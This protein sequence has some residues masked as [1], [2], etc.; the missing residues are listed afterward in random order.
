MTNIIK[1]KNE[2]FVAEGGCQK[3][4]IHPSN[5][6]LCIKISKRGNS[7]SRIINEMKYW[8]IYSKK[9]ICVNDYQFFARY[10]GTIETDLG[11]AGIFDLIK[12]ETTNQFSKTLAFYLQYPTNE[13][14]NKKIRIAFDKLINLMIKYRVIANDLRMENICCKILKNSTIQLIIVD[15]VGHRDFIPIVDWSSFFA[16]KKIERRLIKSNSQNLEI[17]RNYLL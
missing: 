7:Y 13:V 1:I 3:C 9:K 8:S 2:N 6:N 4:Y 12:D 10:Y 16:R 14:T 15:G 17:V 11:T 5:S